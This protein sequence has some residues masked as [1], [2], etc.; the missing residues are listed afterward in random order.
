MDKPK[1]TETTARLVDLLEPFDSVERQ[2]IVKASMMLL[3]EEPVLSQP[4]NK[5]T[6]AADSTESNYAPHAK[7]WMKQHQI[8]ADNLQQVFHVAEGRADV[9][10]SEMPGKDQ[11]AKSINAYILQGLANLL[12][13][14]DSKFDDKTARHLCAKAGCYSAANHS[15]YIKG[16]GNRIAGSKDIGWT[17]TSPGLKYGAELIKTLT[18]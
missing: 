1:I 7:I 13:T 5:L 4:G 2:R 12:V 9:I 18:K 8:S 16:L 15:V 14:G 10:I 6:E 11:K 17:L 3:G